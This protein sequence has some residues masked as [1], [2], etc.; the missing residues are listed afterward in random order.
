V[1]VVAS[2]AFES[3]VATFL[4]PEATYVTGQCVVQETEIAEKILEDGAVRYQP[5]I[6]VQVQN[7]PQRYVGW[8][9]RRKPTW[10]ADRET[11]QNVI[12]RFRPGWVYPCWYASY[13]PSTVI[14]QRS[15]NFTRC[16]ILLVFASFA[17]IGTI[18]MFYTM[19]LFG[20]SA[21][22]RSALAKSAQKIEL[23][24]DL[25][26]SSAY[27]NIPSGENL[28]NSPGVR[29]AYRLPIEVSPAWWLFATLLFSLVWS[30][31]TAVFALGAIADLERGQPNWLLMTLTVGAVVVG[32]WTSYHFLR[33]IALHT[34]VGPTHIEISNHPLL[35]GRDY[36]LHLLQ[37][38]RMHVKKIRVTLICE[39]E[40]TFLHG[41]DVRTEV[42]KVYDAEVA[43]FRGLVIRPG[44][45][46]EE[47]LHF[48]IPPTAMHSFK[49][50]H[51]AVHWKLI[52]DLEVK[53]A[54]SQRRSF[55]IV[56][57]PAA[58]SNA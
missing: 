37:A 20:A 22:R 33:Q 53:G 18:G 12:H 44:A 14:L 11:A 54:G 21:E 43:S 31:M 5:M 48:Q 28:T 7:G 57:Y 29:L 36:K 55:P 23:I 35:P 8:T 16:I 10:Y 40:A 9:Y 13:D 46:F 47:L 39:E 42:A 4:F 24:G 52:V 45:P 51:N 30:A 26:P 6:L 2:I 32:C 25:L 17:T 56:V 27:P 3:T 58:K 50:N 34:R 41:T 38:G 15:I 19:L 1:A 49:S